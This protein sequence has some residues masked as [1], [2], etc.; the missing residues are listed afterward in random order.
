MAND[1]LV[2]VGADISQ[3]SREMGKG[4]KELKSFSGRNEKTFD[5]FKKV[6]EAVTGAGVAMAG[7]LGFAVKTAADFDS[8]MSNVIAI[9]GATG[10]ECDSLRKKAIEMGNVTMF[11]AS[12]SA[13][14]MANLVQMGWET[15]QILGG[16]EHTLNLAA[17]GGLELAD[18][19]MIMANS[20]NQFGMDA[21][22]ADRVAD[23]FAYTAANE[24]TDVTQLGN[25]M[26]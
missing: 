25:A 23:V 9:S 12:E 17:A 11:S 22:E 21:S 26:Q 10:G 13:D 19:A 16:I 24:G 6:G 1:I 5:A 3:Y 18:A 8:S 4:S 15:D 14:V 7:G 20:M 2:K